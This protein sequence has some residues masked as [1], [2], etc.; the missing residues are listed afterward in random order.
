MTHD[1]PSYAT[2]LFDLCQQEHVSDLHLEPFQENYRIRLRIDGLLKVL[3][4][5]P[6]GLAQSLIHHFKTLANR[7]ITE[8][9]RPQEGRIQGHIRLSLCPSAGGEK[10]VLRFLQAP[11]SALSLE[12][13]PFLP[14]QREAVLKSLAKPQGL[15]LVTGPTGSGKTQTLYSMLNHLNT[16]TKHLASIEDPI[17][18]PLSGIVQTEVNIELGLDFSDLL[19]TLLRQDPDILM[20]GEIR[21]EKTAKLS[22]KAA[23]T[24]HLVL[25]TL[26]TNSALESLF[27]LEN[28]GVDSFS[29]A[30][31]LSLVIAQR[32]LRLK[33]A[34]GCF[35]GRRAI[36]EV[37]A[38]NDEIRK[39]FLAHQT[40]PR[41]WISLREHGL[42]LVQEN[43]SSLEELDRVCV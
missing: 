36:F 18:M 37:L 8:N 22:L 33:I 29:L 26:H 21:D 6:S 11:D 15:I 35:Q 7:D 17:E 41:T 28:L 19:R 23:Q 1:A 4:I 34:P 13:L 25:A 12:K 42:K 24:G 20:I 16:S 9:R 40:I 5:V 38:L 14:E 32:L 31:N 2:F 10:C 3:H 30:N 43:L 39:N 27:R